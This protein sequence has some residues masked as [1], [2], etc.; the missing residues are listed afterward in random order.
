[1]KQEVRIQL[2]VSVTIDC[3]YSRDELTRMIRNA[4]GYFMPNNCKRFNELKFAEESQIYSPEEREVDDNGNN[5]IQW[6]V[7][8]DKDR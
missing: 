2:D 4:A 8:H 1:M 3:K 6:N 5:P 7:I